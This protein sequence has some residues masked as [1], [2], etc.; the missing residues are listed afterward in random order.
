MNLLIKTW[1]GHNIN[2]GTNYT[3]IMLPSARFDLTSQAVYADR[4]EYFPYLSGMVLPPHQIT[5]EITIPTGATG[6]SALRDQLKGWFSVLDFQPHTLV[7]WDTDN[8]NTPYQLT[9]F[10][11]R[12]TTDPQAPTGLTGFLIT[13]AITEPV[14]SAVSATTSSWAI[15]GT[16]Q[17][18]TFNNINTVF[19]RPS[20]TITPTTARTG[21]FAYSRW[22]PVYNRVANALNNYSIDVTNGGLNTSALVTAAGVSNQLNG[23]INNSVTTIPINVAVGGGLPNAGFGIVDTEQISWTG[24]TGGTSLTGVTRGIGGT[25]AASHLTAAV[26][27]QSKMLANGADIA[28]QV[29]GSLVNVWVDSPNTSST[30]IWVAQNWQAG[31]AGVLL[32][33]LP[34]SGTAVTVAFTKNSTNL[35]ALT[36]LKTAR[37]SVFL[38]ENEAFAF[39]PANVNLVTYQITSCSRAQKG[40]SFASHAAGVA[41]TWLEHDIYL[42]YGNSA[43]SPFTTDNTQQPL[44]DLH[45]STNTS[46]VQT[47]FF[48]TTSNRPAAWVGSVAVST[49]QQ[50]YVYTGNQTALANPSSE[51][52]LT[53]L[54]YLQA[55]IWKAETATL[56]WSFYHPTGITTVSMS[57]SKRLLIGTAW[58]L[59]AGLQKSISSSAW[60]SVWNEVKPVS[61]NTWTSITHNAVSLSGTY[62]NIRLAL[63][64]TI[65]ATPFS[66]TVGNEADLQGDTV[67]LALDNTLTPVVALNSENS[68]YYLNATIT[69]TTTGD[70]II[71][72][73]PMALNRVLTVDCDKKTITYDDGSNAIGALTLSTTRNDWLTLQPG[74]N[75]Y[76]IDDTGIANI[77]IAMSWND[78]GF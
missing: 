76:Q 39:T 7:A 12:L 14:W 18:K 51:L 73:W 1:N 52:G 16:A 61:L 28:V 68:A 58:P 41:I 22:N 8:A 29:D 67:T 9:G 30:K 2:D 4:A 72:Q 50:S 34:N 6:L 54:N 36:A 21:Q 63:I 65:A 25:S 32:T 17:T 66:T 19:A 24:N 46:W 71:L 23:P 27:T 40:T 3:A 48:D 60:S 5:F 38:V 42:L 78:R 45:N 43:G 75:V 62:K 15:T 70:Y 11:A 69:N 55:N 44:L 33:A 10:P 64:G 37:N 35:A 59:I 77:T 74:N 57:G 56:L 53:L 20:F 26:I 13:L 31:Q 49:G 47:Q